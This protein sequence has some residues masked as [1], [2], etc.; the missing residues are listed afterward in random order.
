M[1]LNAKQ[2]AMIAESYVAG[3]AMTELAKEFEVGEAA[4]WW[5][6]VVQGTKTS[7]ALRDH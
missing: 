6:L 5:T 2:R 3:A 1:R 4:I 7:R